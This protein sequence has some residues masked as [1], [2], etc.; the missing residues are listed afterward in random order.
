[1]AALGNVLDLIL[2]CN[3]NG[4]CH[5]PDDRHAF[6]SCSK[7]LMVANQNAHAFRPNSMI[8]KMPR[9]LD[10]ACIFCFLYSS[11]LLSLAFHFSFVLDRYY[12]NDSSRTVMRIEKSQD[13]FAGRN[14]R[15]LT[16]LEFQDFHKVVNVIVLRCHK[17]WASIPHSRE[18]SFVLF[19]LGNLII[20]RII[21]VKLAF[22]S[23]SRIDLTRHFSQHDCNRGIVRILVFLLF[24][25]TCMLRR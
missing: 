25:S 1:M 13:R 14:H 9:P 11:D 22:K 5:E 18:I 10:D 8:A 23:V 6:L 19:D 12:L 16:V 2:H 20:G 15:S 3:D 7:Q 21:N 24:D 17:I 4:D